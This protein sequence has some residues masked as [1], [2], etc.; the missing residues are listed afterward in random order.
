MPLAAM[1]Q[2]HTTTTGS[3]PPTQSPQAPTA[4][5]M[6]AM[7]GGAGQQWSENFDG[8]PLDGWVIEG[9]SVQPAGQSSALVFSGPGASIAPT[10]LGQQFT[11]SCRLRITQGAAA[12]TFCMRDLEAG[13][14]GYELTLNEE[15]GLISRISGGAEQR[16]RDGRVHLT[17]RDWVQLSITRVGGRIEAAVDGQP[18]I[19]AYDSSPLPGGGLAF[20]CRHGSGVAF[21]DIVVTNGTG[22]ATTLGGG[23]PAPQPAVSPQQQP[24]LVQSTPSMKQVQVSSQALETVRLR[25]L[26][27]NLEQS[28]ASG[29]PLYLHKSFDECYYL[30]LAECPLETIPPLHPVCTKYF[31]IPG[32]NN[33]WQDNRGATQISAAPW[34]PC[35]PP[36]DAT[37]WDYGAYAA[38]FY[39]SWA[40]GADA[41][42]AGSSCEK[43]HL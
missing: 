1:G 8:A 39:A 14:T 9:G 4:A 6:P 42:A 37:I 38:C 11:L 10:T 34:D 16:L 13:G 28:V 32:H 29:R 23:S 36:A 21:D 30:R 2:Q 31:W 33:D 15:M 41:V 17:G 12:V 22:Q 20:S 26:R 3:G 18:F 25:Q 40:G 7:A 27:S 35:H 5:Q 24:Q 19:T 43:E